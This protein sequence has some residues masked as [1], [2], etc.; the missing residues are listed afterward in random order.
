MEISEVQVHINAEG[1]TLVGA[2]EHL[3][4]TEKYIDVVFSYPDQSDWNGSVPYYY[5][6]TALFLESPE[7][8]ASHIEAAYGALKKGSRTKW[9]AAERR[10]WNT[11]HQK[12]SVTK[13]FFDQLLNL[14]WNFTDSDLPPN[15]NPQ[16]RIQDIKEMGYTIATRSKYNPDSRDHTEL[17]K[18]R[19]STQVILLPL[20]RGA[21]TGYE[22]ISAKLR[23]RIIRVLGS[24]DAYEGKVRT[25]GLLPDHKFPEISWDD[26]VRQ[27]N[28]DDMSE[29]EIRTKFQLL[30]NQ[31][32]LEKREAC[33]RVIQTGKLGTIFGINYYVNGIEDWPENA[34]KTGRESEEGWKLCPWYDIE[35]WRQSLNDF[36]A[37][38]QE[39]T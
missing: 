15:S 35:V 31:R 37:E 21:E 3:K 23:R 7:E 32:N 29:E 19:A 6:R 25:S 28:P 36:I 22:V 2:R 30:D 12:K 17:K 1:I 14:K 16:R 39:E 5:R 13:P 9:V 38:N 4:A 11:E 34:P 33:R 24:Y 27:Q 8:I 20:E 18:K 26:D 10:L